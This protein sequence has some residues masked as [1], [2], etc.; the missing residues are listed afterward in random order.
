V[1]NQRGI[2]ALHILHG[3]GTGGAETWMVEVARHIQRHPELGLRV[4]FLLTGAE[5]LALDDEIISTG[6][7]IF[8]VRYSLGKAFAFRRQ[9]L[10]VLREGQ[11]DAVHDHQDFISGWHF[12]LG[13]GA[14]PPKRI[15]HLHNPYNFVHNYVHNPA[16]WFLFRAGRLLV[17]GLAT[18]I[19]G[20]SDAVMDVYGYDKWPYKV[21]RVPPAYCG[22]EPKAFLYDAIARNGFFNERCW[23]PGVRMALFVGR[24]GLQSFDKSVN[25]KNPEFAF[26]LAKYLVTKD[27]TWK[28]LFV[29]FKGELGAQMEQ[30]T[31]ALGLSDHIQF[32]G[33]RR[34]VPVL[35]SAADVLVFPSFWE[36]LGMVAV[37]AQAS[38]LPVLASDT[39]PAEATVITEGVRRL[40]LKEPLEVWY[41]AIR[42][43]PL[44]SESRTRRNEKIAGSPFSIAGSVNYLIKLYKDGS[45]K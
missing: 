11:Y 10:K 45:N 43:T 44:P 23:K 26:T 42:Q 14:L 25:H 41:D 16:R 18:A 36:G 9:F 31:A 17:L 33:L 24:I 27:P 3:F 28:F 21:K 13:I 12:L 4:D 22:F 38:G 39:I 34:D 19:T 1:K 32:L 30:E 29:G 6:A 8:Y 5:K 20:T 35:M 40:S 2:K 37:E 7:R 15:A